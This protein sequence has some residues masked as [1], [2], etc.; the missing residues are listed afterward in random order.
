M[1]EKTVLTPMMQQWH[2]LKKEAKDA[3]LFF[4]LGDFY[5]AFYE[6]ANIMAEAI[7]LT[8]TKRQGIPMCGVPY[9][10]SAS[11]I[12]K[13]LSQGYKIAIA[14]QVEQPGAS[15]GI[16]KRKI[17]RILSPGSITSSS[18]LDEKKDNF[19]AAISHINHSFG[20]SFIDVSTSACI[21][22]EI[23]REEDLFEELIKFAPAEI[24][25]SEK[26]YEQQTVKFKEVEKRLSP[27][28]SLKP[29]KYFDPRMAERE[30]TEQFS[31]SYL[32]GFGISNPALLTALGTLLFYL[33][34]E[35]RCDLRHLQSIEKASLSQ[36]LSLDTATIV[37]LELFSSTQG[38]K[39]SL[40]SLLDRTKTAMGARLL[41]QRIRYPS[42]SVEEIN[43]RLDAVAELL[44]EP[45][46]HMTLM[47]H[48]SNIKDMERLLSKSTAPNGQA[49]DLLALRNSLLEIPSIQEA[50]SSLQSTLF[51]QALQKFINL[52]LL[53]KLLCEALHDEPSLKLGEGITFRPGYNKEL[54]EL[55][56]IERDGKSWMNN[57]QEKLKKEYGI[58]TLKVGYSKAFG[59]F[60]EVSKGQADKM[61]P[62]FHRRQTLVNAERFLSK[63]LEEFEKK[64]LHAEERRKSVELELFSK[65]QDEISSYSSGIRTNSSL[66]AEIDCLSALTKVALEQNYIRPKVDNSQTLEITGGRHPV[67]EQIMEEPF[68]PNDTHLD[69]KT[70]LYL[71]T[72]PNMA[73]KSTYIRQTAL[74]ALLAH[75]GSFVPAVKAHIGLLDKIFSR[76]GASDD[77]SRGQST[78]MVEMTETANILRGATERSLVILDEI[79]RGTSTFDG[80]AIAWAVAEALLSVKAKTLFATHY[81]ELTDLSEKH[82]AV[83]NQKVAVKESPTGII[84]LHKIVKGI[85]DKSYGIHVAKLA[86]L[87]LSVIKRAEIMLQT[88]EK[89]PKEKKEKKK[90]NSDQLPLLQMEDPLRKKLDSCNIDN[91][92]PIDALLFLRDL[93]NKKQ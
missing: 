36:F 7:E 3:L 77:L 88:M 62:S 52:S 70:T 1:S 59:Y 13:L 57:Y 37:N 4:R 49:K 91:M 73:G 21:V 26:F 87:P 66:I 45:Q 20:L 55:I 29:A 80:I 5:E 58:K 48:L 84:F 18:I 32:E 83:T 50:I 24:L 39:G 65:L 81:S 28:F 23:E 54:D 47:D 78:F 61:P 76:I 90:Q 60:I 40:F 67:I 69:E 11:Y 44:S 92:T 19:T 43:Q 56:S 10:A 14:E 85:S 22:M 41:G 25:V 71:I 42:K 15:K 53:T 82:P 74:I 72:G 30:I 27:L 75:I 8:L 2:S 93:K 46:L 17:V 79:G 34:E 38:K 89:A 86:G 51:T 6:D 16:V 33:K 31:I 64:V 68:T 63:E 9:H 12:D 35:M